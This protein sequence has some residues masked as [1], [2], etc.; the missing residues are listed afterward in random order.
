MF[1]PIHHQFKSFPTLNFLVLWRC[2]P[3]ETPRSL[4]STC[5]V[6]APKD[7]LPHSE[8]HP[9]SVQATAPKKK[10]GFCE[11]CQETFAELQMHLQSPRHQDFALDASH[12]AVVD[13]VISQLASSFTELLSWS[14]PARALSPAAAREPCASEGMGALPS[15]QGGDCSLMAELSA[16]AAF[17]SLAE[18]EHSAQPTEMPKQRLGNSPAAAQGFLGLQTELVPWA[19]SKSDGLHGTGSAAAAQISVPED[20]GGLH[21]SQRETL[22]F[23][24][25]IAQS[26]P[27]TPASPPP[28][29][30]KRKYSCSP[31]MQAEKRPRPGSNP[32]SW[33]QPASY[34]KLH[35][36][37]G[38]EALELPVLVGVPQCTLYGICT[39]PSPAP[40]LPQQSL[41]WD[42]N[43]PILMEAG[44]PESPVE[45]PVWKGETL[46]L[47]EELGRGVGGGQAWCP[48]NQHSLPD[49]TPQHSTL[50][51]GSRELA[52]S[53][54]P[55]QHSLGLC[56]HLLAPLLSCAQASPLL[57]VASS[58]S[59]SDWDTKLLLALE[60]TQLPCKR[61]IDAEVLRACVSLQDSS[62]ESHLY[63][64][65]RPAP[66]RDW[67]SKEESC[68][69]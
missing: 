57:E 12:Y 66:E 15:G 44:C 30:L 45:K 68:Q 36:D 49:V 37:V 48:A 64:V 38:G 28:C 21:P 2:S 7:S 41:S 59:Q 51:P 3:F 25:G 11:C 42:M 43:E 29:S 46:G 27:L 31:S 50:C 47:L 56:P 1:R 17:C 10:K 69:T 18:E 62:Y 8:Q 4:S 5:R 23:L 63:A 33:E 58:S 24:P 22:V 61:P 16:G 26:S 65:L 14:P 55:Q 13:H 19:G 54:L 52:R 32:L 34:V 67:L 6:R 35:R 60:A 20:S 39:S 9:C 40:P 53:A